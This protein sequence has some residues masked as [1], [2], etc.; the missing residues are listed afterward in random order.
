MTNCI[1][2]MPHCYPQ[3]RHH[4]NTVKHLDCGNY[5]V[6][7]YYLL[8]PYMQILPMTCTCYPQNKY[9]GNNRMRRTEITIGLDQICLKIYLLY[10]LFLQNLA[11]VSKDVFVK[12]SNSIRVSVHF[13]SKITH[14]QTIAAELVDTRQQQARLWYHMHLESL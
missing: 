14:W 10:P 9:H 1:W 7:S 2:Q 4:H 8:K 13:T 11:T 3:N 12:L 5:A 6:K